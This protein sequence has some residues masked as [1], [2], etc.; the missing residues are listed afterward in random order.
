MII[1]TKKKKIIIIIIILTVNTS[2]KDITSLLFGNN[3][4]S[5]GFNLFP[6]SK[7]LFPSAS[8][9]SSISTGTIAPMFLELWFLYLR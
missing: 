8:L 3:G 7:C 5:S 6:S 1:V 9:P 4:N 2:D